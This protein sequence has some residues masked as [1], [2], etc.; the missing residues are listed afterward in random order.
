MSLIFISPWLSMTT[1]VYSDFSDLQPDPQESNVTLNLF[2][3][4][5]LSISG[6]RLAPLHGDEVL[7]DWSEVICFAKG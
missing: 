3:D 5:D 1:M 6:P 7:H 4:Q 2:Q